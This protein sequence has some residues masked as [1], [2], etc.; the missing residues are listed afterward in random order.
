MLS[1]YLKSKKKKYIFFIMLLSLPVVPFFAVFYFTKSVTPYFP[2]NVKRDIS[3]LEKLLCMKN[4]VFNSKPR[5]LFIIWKYKLFIFSYYL[6]FVSI[7]VDIHIWKYD[8]YDRLVPICMQA[9]SLFLSYVY[10]VLFRNLT[11]WLAFFH[12]FFINFF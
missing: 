11:G 8:R 2:V 1:Y 12:S 3:S 10:M 9:A 4:Y 5:V 6:T 7:L